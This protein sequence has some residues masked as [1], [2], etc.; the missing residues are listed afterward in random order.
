MA[1]AERNGVERLAGTAP[2]NRDAADEPL[3]GLDQ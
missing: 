3:A 2:K 1:N